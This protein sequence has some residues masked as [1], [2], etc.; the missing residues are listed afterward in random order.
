MTTRMLSILATTLVAT[1]A[2][3]AATDPMTGST[4]NELISVQYGRVENIQKVDMSPDYGAGSVIGGALGLLAT[5]GHSGAS[6][7]GGAAVGAGL[8][9]IVAKETA[10]TGERFTVRLV[11]N[12]TVD[13]I[14]ENQDIRL[15]DCVSVEQGKHANIRRVSPV[16]CTT[17]ASH[18]AYGAMNAANV[19]ESQECQEVKRELLNATTEQATAIAYKK[20]RAF[21]ES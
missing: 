5:M 9:A 3:C 19:Q 20:M 14:T 4:R 12:N 13:I 6:Q 8:G 7:V 10:G 2:G 21:C 17:P 11:N 15:G 1:L 18:P 16:M